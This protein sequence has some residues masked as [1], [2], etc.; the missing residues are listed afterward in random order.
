MPSI[1]NGMASNVVDMPICFR[2]V[3]SK[4]LQPCRIVF[5]QVKPCSCVPDCYDMKVP[6]GLGKGGH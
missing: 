4:I 5:I 2:D 3:T 1:T 6:R